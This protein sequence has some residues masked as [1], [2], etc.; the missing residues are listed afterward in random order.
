[1][2]AAFGVL[3]DH[4][5]DGLV[6]A[7]IRPHPVDLPD[8]GGGIPTVMLNA[9]ATRPTATVLAD[10]RA[11]ARRSCDCCSTPGTPTTSS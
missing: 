11:A 5:V 8:V 7:S 1:M 10:E 4:Q 6:Y 3:I 9:V 2:A